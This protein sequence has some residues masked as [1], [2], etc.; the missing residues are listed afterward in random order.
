MQQN[1]RVKPSTCGKKDFFVQAPEG[2]ELMMETLLHKSPAY[3]KAS[4]G[5]QITI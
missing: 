2:L 1:S 5:K 3:A 4:A